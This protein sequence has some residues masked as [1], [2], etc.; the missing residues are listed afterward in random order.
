MSEDCSFHGSAG[1]E[2]EGTRFEGRD[3]VRAAYESIWE[4]FPDAHWG[5]PTHFVAGDRGVSEWLF[6]GTMQD[7]TRVETRGCDL[8]TFVGLAMT[9][10]GDITYTLV[11]PRIDFDTRAA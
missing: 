7:G 1:V 11:D 3:A 8:F 2:A 5:D 9:L 4:A 6:T 10:L